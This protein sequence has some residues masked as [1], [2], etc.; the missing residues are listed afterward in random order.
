MRKRLSVIALLAVVALGTIV[1]IV[2]R[3]TRIEAPG[4]GHGFLIDKHLAVKLKC[5]SCHPENPPA[6]AP[7]WITT[8]L[9][10]HGGSYTNLAELTVQVGPNP[11]ASHQG[12]L[13]CFSCHHVHK[14]S[15]LYCDN[16]HSWDLK[17]P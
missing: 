12:A 14:A 13:P 2:Q 9:N 7:N 4:V 6:K 5:K 10:C 16:C 8:C 1:L 15:E 3:V 17:P 11:H